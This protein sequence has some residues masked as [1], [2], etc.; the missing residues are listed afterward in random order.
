MFGKNLDQLPGGDS[1]EARSHAAIS[2][3]D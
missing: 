3:T 2:M 1:D